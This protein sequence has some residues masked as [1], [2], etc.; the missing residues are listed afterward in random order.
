MTELPSIKDLLYLFYKIKSSY[1][2]PGTLDRYSQT[3]QDL[4]DNIG[5]DRQVITSEDAYAY[6]AS[7]VR[8]KN[9]SPDTK[10]RRIQI[11]IAAFD[12]L[13]SENYLAINP[14][15]GLDKKIQNPKPSIQVFSEADRDKIIGHFH[16]SNPH[17]AGFVE[18]LFGTGCR[19]GEAITLSWK[20]VNWENST[21]LIDCQIG[22]GKELK[23]PKNGKSRYLKL[24]TR[25]MHI[26]HNQREI[27][28]LN[29]NHHIIFPN[30]LGEYI[31]EKNFNKHHWKR[32]LNAAGVEYLPLH[33]T[34]HT[35]VTMC[36]SKGLNPVTIAQFTGH[37]VKVLFDYYAG[38]WDQ[39][40]IPEF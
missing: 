37:R 21:I 2:T 12:W 3:F 15:R 33:H 40:S 26:L 27:H 20:K 9:L 30:N 5:L 24:N 38:L 32:A 39:P 36:I 8:R 25:I 31:H 19:P 1:V 16:G 17:Y 35:F 10:K 7:V 29:N 6:L 4:D 34:R 23:P 22:T 28:T 14:W 13:I 18:F 11:L